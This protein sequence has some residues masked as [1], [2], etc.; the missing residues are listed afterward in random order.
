M[1][2]QCFTCTGSYALMILLG[3][4]R[5]ENR[6][7]MPNPPRGRCAIS[8]SKS[9]CREEYKGFLH[10]ASNSIPPDLFLRLPPWE[11]LEIWRG[12]II[13]ACDYVAYTRTEYSRLRG[14]ERYYSDGVRRL[15]WDEGYKY[16]WTLSNITFF[17][18]PIPCRGNVGMW[19][20]P[21]ELVSAISSIDN[22]S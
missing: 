2:T 22:P 15:A 1:I 5:A 11:M 6:S 12:K 7:M 4:K 19:N 18:R 3:L 17:E 21:P 20:L 14:I 16:W 8:C 13:G 10:W 9:F